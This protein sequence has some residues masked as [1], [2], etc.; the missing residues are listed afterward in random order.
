MHVALAQCPKKRPCMGTLIFDRVIGALFRIHSNWGA[1]RQSLYELL[2]HQMRVQKSWH[3]SPWSKAITNMIKDLHVPWDFSK[4]QQPSTNG[5]GFY[6]VNQ[7]TSANNLILQMTSKIL[8]NLEL[9][10][11]SRLH[12]APGMFIL[13]HFHW[14]LMFLPHFN[15]EFSL[16]LA[17]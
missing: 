17:T 11:L 1:G 14:E 6:P 7:Q 4:C 5:N 9:N 2:G 16:L 13:R 12:S 8:A 10:V 3:D 15:I